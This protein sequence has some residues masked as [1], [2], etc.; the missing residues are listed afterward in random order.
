MIFVAG[1]DTGVGKTLFTALFLLHLLEQGVD[2]IALKP[3]ATGDFGDA[4]MLRHASGGKFPV[5]AITRYYTKVPA[6]PWISARAEGRNLPR[7]TIVNWIKNQSKGHEMALIEGVGGLLVPC[8]KTFT[9]AEILEDLKCGCILVAGNKLGAINHTLLTVEALKAR[10]ISVVCV[11][12]MGGIGR[13]LAVTTNF[14][15]LR[16]YLDGIPLI[17]IPQ[18]ELQHV[19]VESLKNISKKLQKTLAKVSAVSKFCLVERIKPNDKRNRKWSV[20]Q[21]PC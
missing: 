2:A 20:R 15:V 21:K 5:E 3:I 8:G 12:L 17:Q 14:E 18:V 9:T 19:D 10:K 16:E 4:Q 13:S 6:T 11:I 1:T 7:K